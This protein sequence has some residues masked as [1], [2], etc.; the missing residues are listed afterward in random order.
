[1]TR[2]VGETLYDSY[3]QRF[4]ADNILFE[5]KTEHQDL[6]I[7]ENDYFGRVMALDGVIQTTDR[8]EFIYHE[9]I[10]HVPILAHGAARK[11]LII[12]GGDGGVLREVLR[13]EDVD[14]TMVEIDASVVE[15]SKKYFPDHSAGAFENPRCNLVIADGL[16]FVKETTDRF[17]VIIVDST[18]PIGPGE[19]LFTSDFYR[20]CQA[21][22]TEKGILVTQNGVPFFQADE[23]TTTQDRMSPHFKDMSFYVV[24]VPTYIGGFMTL[25]WASNDPAMRVQSVD[26]IEERFNKAGFDTNYYTPG[27]HVGAFS[28]PRYIQKLLK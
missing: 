21:C 8:D 17:D 20:D 13:H 18:D 25:A 24:A 14:C 27:V 6:I 22:L 16:K 7:F 5:E 4:R 23:V 19:V 3:Q 11:V 28:L 1:M 2:W 26:V 12:G 10:S 15:M 9:M